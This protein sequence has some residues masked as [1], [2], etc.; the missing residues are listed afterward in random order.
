MAL[1]KI[2]A[3]LFLFGP[4]AFFCLEAAVTPFFAAQIYRGSQRCFSRFAGEFRPPGA[5][6]SGRIAA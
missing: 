4:A 6:V 3:G 2:Y 1:H 5:R